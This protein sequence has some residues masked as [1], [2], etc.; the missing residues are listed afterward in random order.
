MN[1][2]K[3]RFFSAFKFGAVEQL[4]ARGFDFL[5]LIIVMRVLPTDQIALF[6]IST[7]MLIFFNVFAITPETVVIRDYVK[8]QKNGNAKYCLESFQCFWLL[9]TFLIGSVGLVISFIVENGEL[10]PIFFASLYF[11]IIQFTQLS[12][13]SRIVLRV[14]LE[15]RRIFIIEVALK[16]LLFLLVL[17]IILNPTLLIYY[18]IFAIW[19]ILSAWIWLF[20]LKKLTRA[21]FRWDNSYVKFW[22][23]TIKNFSL[24]QHFGAVTAYFI[25]NIDPWILSLFSVE[26]QEIAE[27]TLALKVSSL[28]FLIPLYIQSMTSI[29]LTNLEW[30]PGWIAELS[31]IWKLNFI[32]SF[33]QLGIFWMLGKYILMIFSNGD[34]DIE[35]AYLVGLYIS[36]GVFFVNIMRPLIG[37]L[38]VSSPMRDVFFKVYF[39][40]FLCAIVIYPYLT[41][42]L[43]PIGCAVAS[44]VVYVI[45]SI[46][47][48]KYIRNSDL[49]LRSLIYGKH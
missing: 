25:Y 18:S 16:F 39:P 43:G 37:Y 8:W 31:K 2:V 6:G 1:E 48:M 32:L 13:I 4:I 24:W 20:E 47:I 15:Q 22:L 28:F 9:K 36:L 30:K 35:K 7:G 38:M 49:T 12:E 14:R 23:K 11:F 33:M 10:G 46:A 5:T 19:A 42:I 27:Y 40:T 29:L 44:M 41:S 3:Q 21:F 34:L 17:L 45:F 26:S